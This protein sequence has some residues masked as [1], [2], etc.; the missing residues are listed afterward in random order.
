LDDLKDLYMVTDM[1]A[2]QAEEVIDKIKS[3]KCD[4]INIKGANG[5][6]ICASCNSKIA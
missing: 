2:V 3:D 4:H 1:Y 6:K 5:G